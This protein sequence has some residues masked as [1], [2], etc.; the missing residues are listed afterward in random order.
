MTIYLPRF[1]GAAETRP[2]RISTAAPTGRADEIVLVVEDEPR[3]RTFSTDAL[4]ELGY[5]AIAA[6]SAE[7][8]LQIIG[9]GRT[10]SLLFTDIIMPGM[11]G[12]QLA[13][14][15]AQ[16]VP[17]MKVVFTSGFARDSATPDGAPRAVLMKP[18]SIE[19]LALKVREALDA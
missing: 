3:V 8:A 15:A 17:S 2:Q 6:A 16:A 4:N 5:T 19:Q 12:W 13:E 9:S 11:S 18:F 10:I 14:I 7:E 1:Q